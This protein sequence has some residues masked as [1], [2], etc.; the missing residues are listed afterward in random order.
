MKQYKGVSLTRTD[1]R[2]GETDVSLFNRTNAANKAKADLYV[3]FH[4]N[5]YLS[6]WGS[7]G[8]VET[9]YYKGNSKGQK[10]AQ[11][12]QKSIV[13][14]YGLRN[15]GIKTNNLHITR[16]TAM[17]AI[18]IEGCFM[19]STTD[20]KKLRDKKVLQ[21][22]GE[23]IAKAVAS[24]L[25]LSKSTSATSKPTTS[26]GKTYKVVKS[27]TGYATAA[28]A[29]ARKN[30]KTTV[31]PST[32]HV[33]KESNGMINVSTKKGSPGSWINPADNKKYSRSTAS[34]PTAYKNKSYTIQQVGKDDVLLKELY[35]WVKKSDVQ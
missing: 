10:L 4:H 21:I 18:L 26:T 16:E 24:Y 9:Y 35:S 30:K 14:A 5:A 20:I 22:A 1:D 32:Y 6:A 27:I 23:E 29:K 3:S 17:T 8:G 31:K 11:M 7:H 2:T 19:D 28:D 15:R 12:V 13:K 34:I 33:Y 25:G